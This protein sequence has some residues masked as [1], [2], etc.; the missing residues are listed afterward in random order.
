MA[1]GDVRM[2]TPFLYGSG[3]P[4]SGVNSPHFLSQSTVSWASGLNMGRL[5]RE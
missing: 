5:W 3:T 4:R 1:Y 2:N